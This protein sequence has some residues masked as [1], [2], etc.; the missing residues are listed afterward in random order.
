MKISQA[1]IDLIKR[2]EGLRLNAHLDAVGV[3]TIGYGSTQGVQMG[4]TIT[5]A[6]AEALLM[7]DLARF[8]DGVTKLV[9]V[10]IDQNAFDALVSFSFNLGLGALAGSTLLKLVNAGD[11]LGASKEFSKWK[12]AG[13]KVLPGLVARRAAESEL[14]MA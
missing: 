10:P 8:E 11:A 9:K 4:D 5:E 7:K 2:F 3:P 13:G 1:G 12:H 6:E 14:F